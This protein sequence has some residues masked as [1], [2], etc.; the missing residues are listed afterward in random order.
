MDET[1]SV[2]AAVHVEDGIGGAE[3]SWAGDWGEGRLSRGGRWGDRLLGGDL[4]LVGDLL[5]LV[6]GRLADVHLLGGVGGVGGS[7]GGVG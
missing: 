4:L 6:Q 1:V 2:G 7:T 3:L 5:R